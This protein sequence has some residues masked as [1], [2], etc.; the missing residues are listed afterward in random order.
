M[1]AQNPEARKIVEELC[2]S[3][4]K[5]KPTS[6]NELRA[7][8]GLSDGALD[9]GL[10]TLIGLGAVKERRF[11]EI[12]QQKVFYEVASGLCREK[13]TPWQCPCFEP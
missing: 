3:A 12:H 7:M 10:R 13:V 9:R 1:I 4:D 11:P 6:H 8:T 5:G 2:K